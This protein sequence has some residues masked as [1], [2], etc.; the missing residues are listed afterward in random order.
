MSVKKQRNEKGPQLEKGGRAE[1]CL[2]KVLL[3]PQEYQTKLI[4]T[5]VNIKVQHISHINV[6]VQNP[7]WHKHELP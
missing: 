3:T 6:S 2:L 5:K 1:A 7:M 4:K